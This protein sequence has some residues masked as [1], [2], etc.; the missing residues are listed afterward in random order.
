MRK[1]RLRGIRTRRLCGL[2]A[3]LSMA[4]A[5]GSAL[6]NSAAEGES[7]SVLTLTE[8]ERLYIEHRDA[9]P[10]DIEHGW[11][12]VT[13]KDVWTLPRRA[14]HQEAWYRARFD[15]PGS[16]SDSYALFVPRVSS[17]ASFW[18]NG[19]EIG[20]TGGFDGALPRGWNHPVFYTVPSALLNPQSNELEIRLRVVQSEIGFLFEVLFGSERELRDRY[21]WSEFGK[22]T[23]TKILTTLI[24]IGAVVVLGFYFS[25][26]LPR[27]YLWFA[28]GCVFWSIYSLELFI[29]EVPM[30]T[31]VWTCVYSTALGLALWFFT[32]T[33]HRIFGLH[34]PK[35]EAAIVFVICT[36]PLYLVLPPLGIG[37]AAGGAVL[38]SLSVIV[39]LGVLLTFLGWRQGGSQRPWLVLCGLSALVLITADVTAGLL[40]MTVDFAKYPYIPLFAMVSGATIFVQR[41]IRTVRDSESFPRVIDEAVVGAV[42]TERHRLMQEIHDGVG[43]QIITALAELERAPATN[44]GAIDLLRASVSELRLIVHSLEQ[45]SQQGDI[46]T[47]LATLRERL[48]PQLNRGGIEFRWQVEPVANVERIGA[49]GALHFM[50]IVQEAIVNVV[51]HAG[52]TEICVSA[53]EAQRAAA[54][55]VLVEVSDNGRGFESTGRAGMGL[56]NMRERAMQ[57]HATL[58]VEPSATGTSVSIWIPREVPV[59]EAAALPG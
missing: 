16:E 4:A 47:I 57:L 15:L 34:R 55:G 31:R 8:F 28:L 3:I 9:P 26:R 59:P 30:P 20:D 37:L 50:R 27:T 43:G 24:V 14:R 12:P 23:A 6:S 44:Q 58:T 39:Y 40:G 53:R 2:L 32:R 1:Q 5:S 49:D 36:N 29:R 45:M 46:V 42:Q 7:A 25:V 33:V 54:D 41:L 17:A 10:R 56:R 18:V 48:E 52:A 38:L 21:T 22:L 35:L 13:L 11:Q 51:Q 19:V